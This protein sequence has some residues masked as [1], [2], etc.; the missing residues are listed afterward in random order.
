MLDRVPHIADEL[1]GGLAALA[2]DGLVAAVRGEGAIWAMAMTEGMSAFDVRAGM[3][4]RG[5]IARPIG[6]AAVAFCPPLMI[7]DDDLDQCL[8]AARQALVAART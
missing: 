5:V 2:D 4:E 8:D 6:A 1:G 7:S 3:L